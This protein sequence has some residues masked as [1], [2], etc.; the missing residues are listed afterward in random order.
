MCG[1]YSLAEPDKRSLDLRL[2][3]KKWV[4]EW[5]GPRYNIAP[6]Q[7]VLTVVQNGERTAEY[8]RWGVIPFWSKTDKLKYSTINA[9]DDKLLE[10]RIYK[11]LLPGR[12]CLIV[13]DGFYE[14]RKD[15]KAKTP[16][17][18]ILKGNEPFGF[19]GLWSPW[20]NP[21]TGEEIK[22]CTIIT[23][24]PNDLLA[25]IH[26]RMPVILPQEAEAMWLDTRNQNTDTLMSLLRP[27][28]ADSME[29]YQVSGVVGNSRNEVPECIEPVQ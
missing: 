25:T 29:A 16:M 19:A 26:N 21:E 23:T 11:N 8:M 15:G 3:I 7:N 17:R 1:R 13:A 24:K 2:D 14:W 20:R 10:S 9:R 22:T 4:S 12:R 28:P 5:T 27:F 18:I 6:T